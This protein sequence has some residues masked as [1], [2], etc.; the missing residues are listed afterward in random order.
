[1]DGVWDGIKTVMWLRS[2]LENPEAHD[3]QS[4]LNILQFQRYKKAFGYR[5]K[6]RVTCA[7]LSVLFLIINT[8]CA[9]IL[10]VLDSAKTVVRMPHHINWMQLM[11]IKV[12]VR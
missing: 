7:A 12:N 10:P 2:Y 11:V 4:A 9:L 3:F 1:M 6:R 8:I 5:L